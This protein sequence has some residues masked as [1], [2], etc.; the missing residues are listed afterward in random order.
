MEGN[1]AKFT[2]SEPM[3]WALLSTGNKILVEASPSDSIWGIG[4]GRE[5]A[6]NLLPNAQFEF[7]LTLALAQV[8]LPTRIRAKPKPKP[9]PKPKIKAKAKLNPR[10][11]QL[12]LAAQTHPSPETSRARLWG[13]A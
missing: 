12:P 5:E 7:G 11:N 3:K 13:V 1:L 4:H 10:P 2:A 9:K 8:K 6:I